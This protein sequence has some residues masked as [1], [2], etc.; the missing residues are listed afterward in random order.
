LF[1]GRGAKCSK[2][3]HKGANAKWAILRVTTGRGLGVQ[4][5]KGKL[6]A[7]ASPG[8]EAGKTEKRPICKR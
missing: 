2:T 5:L 4:G 3:G 6:N 1:A 7:K 8:L